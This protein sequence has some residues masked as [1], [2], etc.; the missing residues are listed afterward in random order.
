VTT[1]FEEVKRDGGQTG[2]FLGKTKLRYLLRPGSVDHATHPRISPTFPADV[3]AGE[4]VKH[5]AAARPNFTFIHLPDPDVAG[6]TLGWMSVPYLA[7]VK[8]ADRAVASVL[9]QA[10]STFG[11]DFVLIVTAD[12]GGHDR[13]HGT[14]MQ[15][16][17][18]IPWI[19]SG[20]TVKQGPFSADM[21]TYDTAATALWLLGIE[22]PSAW[23][24]RPVT[25]AFE[26]QV[27]STR[28]SRT[29][30]AGS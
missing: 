7:A 8:L 1:V 3:V 24:A 20:R 16:D 2:A 18:R 14:A 19:A 12:H 23:D 11:N 25:A 6:H 27:S 29:V 30:A 4:A 15:E 5:L 13:T 10:R 28:S 22:P 26:A 9:E 21:V 17:V